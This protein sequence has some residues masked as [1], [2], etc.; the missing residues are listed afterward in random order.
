MK[1]RC[2]D[3]YYSI[4][5]SDIKKAKTKKINQELLQSKNMQEYFKSHPE[6]K[7]SIIKSI[8]ENSIKSFKPSAGY[9]PSY[10]IHDE[11]KNNDIAQVLL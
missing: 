6:E 11:N 3:I 4:K 8:S 5:K 10:L 1:Y 9:I 2:E 7:R